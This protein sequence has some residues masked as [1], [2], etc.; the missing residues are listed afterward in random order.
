MS[1]TL[2]FF[3][4]LYIEKSAGVFDAKNVSQRRNGAKFSQREILFFSFDHQFKTSI[5][6][7]RESR[8]ANKIV[9]LQS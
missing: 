3:L 8:I 4:L 6:L 9:Y 7:I 1:F 5:F 2:S